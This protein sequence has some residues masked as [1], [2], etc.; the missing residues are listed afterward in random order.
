MEDYGGD[1][2]GPV[3]VLFVFLLIIRAKYSEIGR[4]KA[5]AFHCR[6]LLLRLPSCLVWNGGGT[7][8]P[9]GH[10]AVGVRCSK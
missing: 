4:T 6:Y 9:G 2:S 3:V 10:F 7:C 5:D 1:N 8:D